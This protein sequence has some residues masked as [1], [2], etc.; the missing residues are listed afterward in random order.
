MRYI[1][2]IEIINYLDVHYYLAIRNNPS[3][4]IECVL[5]PKTKLSKNSYEYKLIKDY[6]RPRDKYEVESFYH[7][8]Y[9]PTGVT[10][11]GR[12]SID[13]G[14][15]FSL[16]PQ[17]PSYLPSNPP[18]RLFVNSDSHVEDK[19]SS[20]PFSAIRSLIS[21]IGLSAAIKRFKLG[22]AVRFIIKDSFDSSTP[23]RDPIICQ[24][25]NNGFTKLTEVEF[26]GNCELIDWN[27]LTYYNEDRNTK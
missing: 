26:L 18:K 15:L 19:V 13:D 12:G 7:F 5:H 9:Y 10:K 11:L 6:L 1:I 17:D 3:I 24:L 16:S 23:F 20:T 14:K 4:E 27:E 2:V 22:G 25:L 21:V 8:I